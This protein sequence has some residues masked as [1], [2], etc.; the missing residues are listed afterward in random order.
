[1]LSTVSLHRGFPEVSRATQSK[2]ESVRN[3]FRLHTAGGSSELSSNRAFG[4]MRAWLLTHTDVER[5]IGKATASTP[6]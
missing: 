2:W 5:V 6:E 3:L 4:A 1:M